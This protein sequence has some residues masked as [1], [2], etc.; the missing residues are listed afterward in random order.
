MFA[1]LGSEDSRDLDGLTFLQRLA[2]AV[3]SGRTAF[4]VAVRRPESGARARRPWWVPVPGGAV[5][6]R[7]L[8][9][10]A[11]GTA[12]ET[13]VLFVVAHRVEWAVEPS[14][15]PSFFAATPN[16]A[17][18]IALASLGVGIGFP[19]QQRDSE[20]ALAANLIL[21]LPLFT[22]TSLTEGTING[23]RAMAAGRAI[24][25][26][27]L[28]G[29]RPPAA[30]SSESCRATPGTTALHHDPRPARRP[31][32]A[33]G[34]NRGSGQPPLHGQ[35]P[36]PDPPGRDHLCPGHR[37]QDRRDHALAPAGAPR[38]RH[39]RR[40]HELVRRQ[41]LLRCA[42]GDADAVRDD[43]RACAA[44]H[45]GTDGAMPSVDGP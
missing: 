16:T 30:P 45:L 29:A 18:P 39:R 4:A 8:C 35:R 32:P 42:R 3:I 7:M 24:T 25:L 33:D 28:L 41:H 5:L 37:E 44:D 23:F 26:L 10:L 9:F 11:L 38:D 31:V 27:G 1:V 36:A 34:R 20:R 22:I 19:Q 15:S 14:L 43:L 2:D 12:L 13:P 17:A 40:V 21:R 6:A